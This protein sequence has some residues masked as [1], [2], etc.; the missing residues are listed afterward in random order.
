MGEAAE[1]I[2]DGDCCQLCGE[3]FLDDESPGYPR[4]CRGCEPDQ[5][6]G[7]GLSARA[8]KRQRYRANRAKRVGEADTTG[9]KQCSPYHYQRKYGEVLCNWWPS[10]RKAQIGGVIH[11]IDNAEQIQTIAVLMQRKTMGDSNAK[12]N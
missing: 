9:W 7:G 2:L 5:G 3:F 10:S 6:F 8:R 4:S 12:G 1:A 11:S